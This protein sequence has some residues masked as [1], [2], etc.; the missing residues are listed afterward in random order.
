MKQKTEGIGSWITSKCMEVRFSDF[1]RAD[2]GD[3]FTEEKK[4]PANYFP[5]FYLSKWFH[6]KHSEYV[7][8]SNCLTLRRDVPLY[9]YA[10]DD[11][12]IPEMTEAFQKIIQKW[13][14]DTIV[15]IDAGKPH[16]N[17]LI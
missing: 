8:S 12:T 9:T 6:N 7:P 4:F 3:L 16:T 5:E 14:I 15:L 13:N 2:K 1:L 17:D 11:I 10:T